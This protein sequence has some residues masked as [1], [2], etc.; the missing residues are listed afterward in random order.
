MTTE[1][2]ID[3][4]TSIPQKADYQAANLIFTDDKITMLNPI[5]G[6]TY[7][8]MMSWEQPIMDVMADVCVSEGD[9]VLECGFGMGILSDAIQAKNP[10][11]HTI[12]E[13]HPDIIPRLQ[14]WS[15]DKDNVKIWEN[16]WSE[17]IYKP[18]KYDAILMDTFADDPL[19]DRFKIFCDTKAGKNCK[20]SW[21]NNSGE[22][23]SRFMDSLWSNIAFIDV[24]ISPPL[25]QYYNKQVYKIPL[26]ILN[27]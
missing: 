10:A 24:A 6:I 20:V 8:V 11:S 9:H 14:A 23:T 4:G 18:E 5:D 22:T 16:D 15:K 21:W 13:L 27:N 7:E 1:P 12:C 25:N 17:L 3:C 26:K 19:S 2:C